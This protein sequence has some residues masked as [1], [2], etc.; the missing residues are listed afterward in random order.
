MIKLEDTTMTKKQYFIPQ[1]ETLPLFNAN[2]LCAG[3]TPTP[4]PVSNDMN[5]NTGIETNEVW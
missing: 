5:V 1:V 2:A 4:P 3:S